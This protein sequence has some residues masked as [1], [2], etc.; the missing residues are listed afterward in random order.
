MNKNLEKLINKQIFF[1]PPVIPSVFHQNISLITP[2]SNN[3]RLGESVK[4]GGPFS[5]PYETSGV[6]IVLS[7]KLKKKNYV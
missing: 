2:F 4:T 7:S 6:N 3:F 5:H 1:Q